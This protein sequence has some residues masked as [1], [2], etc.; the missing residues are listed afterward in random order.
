[1][2]TIATV[3]VMLLTM[4]ISYAMLDEALRKARTRNRMKAKGDRTMRNLRF[5]VYPILL[6][7]VTF[8]MDTEA[9]SYD[10]LESNIRINFGAWDT[11]DSD[12]GITVD[13]S[14]PGDIE[15]FTDIWISGFSAGFS[16]SRMVNQKFAWEVSMGGLSDGKIET[17]DVS[18]GRNYYETVYYDSRVVSVNYL[19]VG[20]IYYPLFELDHT[21]SSILGR[22]GSFVRPYMTAGVGPYFGWDVM[23]Y[24]DDIIDVDF[25]TSTGVYTGIGMDFLLSRHFIFNVD[26][27][28]HFVEFG[29][30][31]KGIE[32]Y[33]GVNVLAGL[34]IAL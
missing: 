15:R 20:L 19:A 27:R 1:M 18:Y 4:P 22:P 25:A 30:S 17:F 16:F 34:K 7:A 9:L 33:S 11:P 2:K 5:I 8:F 23:S 31:L 26:L 13:H 32:D 14:Y 29:D 24:D 3:L 28:Y 6:I 12:F 21:G 10:H